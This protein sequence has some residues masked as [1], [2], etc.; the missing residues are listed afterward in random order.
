MLQRF[1]KIMLVGFLL[2]LDYNGDVFLLVLLDAAVGALISAEHA[3]APLASNLIT[4]RWERVVRMMRLA[5]F[6]TIFCHSLLAYR[7]GPSCGLPD[8]IKVFFYSN[9]VKIRN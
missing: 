2:P 3:L 4:F 7:V 6:V 9:L 1:V 5:E 8:F